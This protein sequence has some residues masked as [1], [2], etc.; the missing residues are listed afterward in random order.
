MFTHTVLKSLAEKK[1]IKH[2]PRT[3][4]VSVIKKYFIALTS[5]EYVVWRKRMIETIIKNKIQFLLVN[6]TMQLDNKFCY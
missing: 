5:S 4:N 6:L 3:E 1:Y 2:D